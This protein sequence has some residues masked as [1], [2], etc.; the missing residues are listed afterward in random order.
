[1]FAFMDGIFCCVKKNKANNI[2]KSKTQQ[3]KSITSKA[4]NVQHDFKTN[5]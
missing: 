1:M 5:I 4:I 2:Q 3:I